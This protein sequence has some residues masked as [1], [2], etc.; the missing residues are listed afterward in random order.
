MRIRP[1]IVVSCA[2]VSLLT[3]IAV[4]ALARLPAGTQLP[5]H[6]NAAGEADRFATAAHALFMPVVVSAGIS[7]FFAILPR[8]EPLQDRMSGSRALLDTSWTGLLALMLLTQIMIAAPAFGLALAPKL[9]PVGAG[10]L[11]IAI[12]NALPKS[13]P[14]FFV[15]IRTPWTLADTDTWIA[16]HRLASRTMVAGGAMIVASAILPIGAQARGAI[17]SVALA[18]TIVPPVVYS[19]W[20]W[21]R[22]NA[23]T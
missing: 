15:G 1:L 9:I 5:V 23:R 8:I 21:H 6:W 22:K 13:R 18:V 4:V 16:T 20:F 3:M 11:L 12:G 7:A 17:V 10:L 2:I 19:W 14:G